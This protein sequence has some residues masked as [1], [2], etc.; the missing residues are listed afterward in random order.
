MKKQL[1]LVI[2]CLALLA[3]PAATDKILVILD[4]ADIVKTHSKFFTMLQVSHSVEVVYSFGTEKIKLKNYDR[5]KYDHVIV[6]CLSSKCNPYLIQNRAARLRSTIL[7]HSSTKEEMLS[8]WETLIP[9]NLLGSSS[10]PSAL[11]LTNS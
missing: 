8:S 11:N 5:F 3:I 6:M 9:P 2:V 10:M 7:F 4:N 1:V